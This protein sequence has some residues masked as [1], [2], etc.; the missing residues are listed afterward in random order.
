[1]QLKPVSDHII[2]K[3]IDKETVTS[4]GI[5]IPDTVE[6]E[7]PEQAEVLAVGPG[8]MLENGQ[9]Q[10]IEVAVGQKIMFKKW[11]PDEVEIE[12]QKYL[13]IKSEDVI[14]IVE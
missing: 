6:K 3:P 1:M 8:K 12:G 7:K 11:T 14:A 10:P 5:I 4:S 13:I 2:L 9:R